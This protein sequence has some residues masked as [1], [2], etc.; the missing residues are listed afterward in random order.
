MK[1]A[2]AK[3]KAMKVAAVVAAKTVKAKKAA[4][5]TLKKAKRAIR[6]QERSATR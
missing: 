5:H 4:D 6:K 2:V 1:K 3:K